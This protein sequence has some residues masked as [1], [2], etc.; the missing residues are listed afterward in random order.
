M[1]DEELR[2]ALSKGYLL[3]PQTPFYVNGKAVEEIP[4]VAT[5][6]VFRKAMRVLACDKPGTH[7]RVF[8][9]ELCERIVEETRK[10]SSPLVGK[11]GLPEEESPFLAEVSHVVSNLRIVES[12]EGVEVWC[13]I[14]P[15]GTP[16]GLALCQILEHQPGSVALS[17]CGTGSLLPQSDGTLR[18][19]DDYQLTSIN[20]IPVAKAVW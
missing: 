20:V 17:A 14:Q 19:S 13:D 2:E 7:R 4:Q 12:P 3:V 6:S 5:M 8:P 1:S 10:R 9:R 15:I 16:N 18:V 11:V